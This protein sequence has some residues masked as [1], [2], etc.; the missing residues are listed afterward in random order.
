MKF[1]RISSRAGLRL[2]LIPSYW[3]PISSLLPYH[4]SVHSIIISL[5]IFIK[6]CVA[7]QV[8]V[9]NYTELFK[10]RDYILFILCSSWYMTHDFCSFIWPFALSPGQWCDQLCF[11]MNIVCRP[12][13]NVDEFTEG[14][15]TCFLHWRLKAESLSQPG[16]EPFRRALSLREEKIRRW[17]L[18]QWQLEPPECRQGSERHGVCH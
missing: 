14:I 15:Q 4:H 12:C 10:S 6:L 16:V 7:L 3:L 8:C 1:L 18:T 13:L 5:T 2:S 11:L 17:N 9:P